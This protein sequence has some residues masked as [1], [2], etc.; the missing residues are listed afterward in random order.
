MTKNE[1]PKK[2]ASLNG[3]NNHTKPSWLPSLSWLFSNILISKPTMALFHWQACNGFFFWQA[4][5]GF[6]SHTSLP[7]LSAYNGFWS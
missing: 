3:F 5:N 4:Y 7:W 6:L 2:L 1:Q